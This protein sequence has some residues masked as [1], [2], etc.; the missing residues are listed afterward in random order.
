MKKKVNYMSIYLISV[1]HFPVAIF[2]G[3]EVDSPVA[4]VP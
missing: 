4:W 1:N 2:G 3:L